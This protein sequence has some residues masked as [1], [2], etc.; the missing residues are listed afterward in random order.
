M[1]RVMR[2]AAVQSAPAEIGTDFELFKQQVTG[3]VQRHPGIELLIFP[4]LQLFHSSARDDEPRNAALRASGVSLNSR[5]VEQLAEL[6]RSFGIWLSPGSICETGPNGELF[7]TAVILSPDGELIS[8]YHK[9]FPWRPYEP[10]TPGTE[11]VVFDIPAVGRF[12]WSICYD[13]WFP[14]VQRHLAWMGA[15]VILNVVKTTTPDRAQEKLLVR[16]N[17]IFNQTFVISVNCAGPV[18]MGHS[19]MVDPEGLVLETADHDDFEVLVHDIDLDH[20]TRVREIG[21]AGT[22]RMWSQ[23]LPE[24][25]RIPLPLYNGYINPKTWKPGS[26]QK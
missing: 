15:E 4:E 13:I 3:I 24:D 9:M 25:S 19:L 12:G 18:G 8:S 17:A 14:E 2:I 22:N 7:N 10:Y 26:K 20:V 6:A 11:F 5:L 23:F 21:T 16:A 1:A